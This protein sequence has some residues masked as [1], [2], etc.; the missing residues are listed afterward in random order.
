MNNEIQKEKNDKKISLLC[1]LIN[2][3]SDYNSLDEYSK[4]KKYAIK[5]DAMTGEKED[6]YV[7][8]INVI[9]YGNVNK[10]ILNM[11][12]VNNG[13][14]FD[15][16]ENLITKY[17]NSNI[18]NYISYNKGNDNNY[19]K[20]NINLKNNVVIEISINNEQD[21]NKIKELESKLENKCIYFDNSNYIEKNNNKKSIKV[22]EVFFDIV[23]RLKEYNSL[24]NYNN[25]KP[26]MF[27]ISN[28]YNK[29]KK[30]YVYSFNIL[31]GNIKKE[32]VASISTE[33]KDKNIIYNVL[34]KYI[35][36]YKNSEEFVYDTYYV[37][38]SNDCYS[39]VLNNKIF[40]K[41]KI[42]DKLDENYYHTYFKD[43]KELTLN[44]KK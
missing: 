14:S 22:V 33:V 19:N 3:L 32:N 36:L 10:E 17:L 35:E 25:I 9:S 37:E 12:F 21:L 1:D 38:Q 2:N 43:D 5:I 7:Y 23:S 34:N 24:E 44:L 40:I 16:I 42:S 39:V 41:F 8:L 11:R 6:N 30:C 29:D 28:Y 13:Y 15:I 26:F 27:E 31:R 18:F 4:Q 20:L